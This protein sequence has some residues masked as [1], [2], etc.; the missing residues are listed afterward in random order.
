MGLS[1]ALPCST[2]GAVGGDLFLSLVFRW[3]VF[4][5]VLCFPPSQGRCYPFTLGLPAASLP[6]CCGGDPEVPWCC[7]GVFCLWVCNSGCSF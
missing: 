5:F 1:L 4:S 7:P 2:A 3:F 6:S